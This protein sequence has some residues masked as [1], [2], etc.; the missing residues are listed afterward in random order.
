MN[1]RGAEAAEITEEIRN[2]SDGDAREITHGV[3]GAA[4][5]V[6]RVL[7][8]GLLESV[9]EEALAIELEL[10]GIPF[11]RQMAIELQYKGRPIGQARLDLL[12]AGSLV[13]ELKAVEHLAAVHTA[14]VLSYLRATRHRRGLL[15]TFN[16]PVLR[17]GIKRLVYTHDLGL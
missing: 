1:H 2:G 3:I 16:V 12:V 4:I 9:Y 7:G 6:H 8:P 15:I 14:Q 17:L 11:Q 5:E 10:R 13:V